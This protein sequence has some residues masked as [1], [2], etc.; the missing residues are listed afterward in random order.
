[1]LSNQSRFIN[2][3]VLNSVLSNQLLPNAQVFTTTTYANSTEE[4]IENIIDSVPSETQ[5]TTEEFQNILNNQSLIPS[6][7]SN[8]DTAEWLPFIQNYGGRRRL[9]EFSVSLTGSFGEF[10]CGISTFNDILFDKDYTCRSIANLFQSIAMFYIFVSF[11][12]INFHN[13]SVIFK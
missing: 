5:I 11:Y 4:Y 9:Q 7:L 10:T 1:M 8:L 2:T 3:S 13:C 12:F 6:E